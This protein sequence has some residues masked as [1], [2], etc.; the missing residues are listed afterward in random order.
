MKYKLILI[1]LTLSF[2]AQAQDISVKD[3]KNINGSNTWF[4]IG[5]N[6]GLPVSDL[7]N[8]SSFAPGVDLSVQYLKTKAYGYGLKVGYTHYTAKNASDEDFS[9][10][11][12]AL[13]FRFYPETTGFF[14]GLEVGYAF[15]N[16]LAGT[17][18][19]VMARPQIGYHT[20]N[21]NF[22]VYYDH[23]V[24]EETV[25][26]LQTLGLGLTYNLRWNN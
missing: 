21:W 26:D 1:I 16:N 22:F 14:G 5:I 13:L 25:I 20:D 8:V 18:G 24:T 2:C 3:L 10:I 15:I 4:K 7:A 12:L 11:P 6:L 9:A 19:G 23:T 17:S